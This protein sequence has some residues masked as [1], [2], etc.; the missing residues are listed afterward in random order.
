MGATSQPENV[1]D[2]I[3]DLQRQIN[4]LR[5]NVGVGSAVLSRGDVTITN[6][7]LNVLDVNGNRIVQAGPFASLRN[8]N[9]VSGLWAGRHDGTTAW[10]SWT[11]AFGNG[12][13]GI[14]DHAGNVIV[15]DDQLSGTGLARPWLP[16]QAWPSS[17]YISPPVTTTSATFVNMWSV[18]GLVQH[19]VFQIDMQVIM[20]DAST[21]GQLQVVDNTGGAIIEPPFTIGPGVSNSAFVF[22]NHPHAYNSIFRY[23]VQIKRVTGVGTIGLLVRY[24]QGRQT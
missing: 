13:V 6:G 19:P 10:E 20:S 1:Y 2:R 14:Y 17:Y 4:E 9:Q 3:D 22:D 18:A 15:S 21:T 23:D 16:Y 8:G 7:D 11:D 5:K 12:F 24:A